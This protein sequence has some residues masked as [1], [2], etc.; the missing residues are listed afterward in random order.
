MVEIQPENATFVPSEQPA[1][2]LLLPDT[3]V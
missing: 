3:S 2:P 1:P